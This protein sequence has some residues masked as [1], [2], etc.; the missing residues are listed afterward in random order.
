MMP[1][2]DFSK[3]F[4]KKQ[5]NETFTKEKNCT[6]LIPNDISKK[7]TINLK[8]YFVNMYSFFSRKYSYRL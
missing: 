7:Q 6:F 4:P 5:N 8:L 1:F 2:E 3:I